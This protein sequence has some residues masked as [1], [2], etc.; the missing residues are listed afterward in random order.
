MICKY[1]F[2]LVYR[3]NKSILIINFIFYSIKSIAQPINISEIGKL[4]WKQSY[5]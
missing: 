1:Q 5:I 3:K 2:T 4:L